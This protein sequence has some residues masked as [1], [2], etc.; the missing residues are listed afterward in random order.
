MQKKITI[1]SLLMIAGMC[2]AAFAATPVKFE[3][4]RLGLTLDVM[5]Q[6]AGITDT[7][8]VEIAE[9][10][11]IFAIAPNVTEIGTLTLDGQ[12]T[13]Y[14]VA[15]S[16]EEAPEDIQAMIDTLFEAQPT[17]LFFSSIFARRTPLV[18]SYQAVFA[19][20]VE[21]A[22][23]ARENVGREVRG[24]IGEMGAYLSPS[25]F[26]YPRGSEESV[27]FRIT[28]DIPAEWECV[29]DGNRSASETIDGRK[30]QT[31]E[32]PYRNDGLM[33]MAAPYVVRSTMR[34][35]IEVA[36]YFF[37]ADTGLFEQYLTATADYITMYTDLIGPYPFERFTVAEN[38][39]PTGYGMPG[40]T[41]LGQQVLRMPWIVHTSLG[42]E[43]L[44]NWWGNSVYV[45]YVR[46]NWCEAATVY[47]ADYRYKLMQS[48]AAARDYRKDILKEYLSYVGEGSDFPIRAFTSRT[49]PETRTIGYNKAMMVYHLIHE[50]I[51]DSA[52]FASWKD[53]YARYRGVKIGWEEWIESFERTSG[54]DLSFIIPQWIDGPGAPV[55]ELAKAEI[56]S[57]GAGVNTAEIVVNETSGD[58]YRLRVPVRFENATETLDTVVTIADGSGSVT[59]ALPRS[60]ET[61][62]V[63][64]EYNIFRKLY[65]VEVE[66]IISAV[67]GSES[68][69]YNTGIVE[70]EI[71]DKIREFIAN[72]EGDEVEVVVDADFSA[73]NQTI[74]VIAFNPGD[75]PEYLTDRIEHSEDQVA[76]GNEAY[77]LSKHSL[78]LAV[79]FETGGR[80]LVVLTKDLASLPRL[81]QLIPHYGK[82][83]YLVFEGTKNI[84]KGQWEVT[85]SPLKVELTPSR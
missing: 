79:D 33:F 15:H 35:D 47:G 65:D 80:G 66:P 81:G 27:K 11:N 44:H 1:A 18:I 2:A 9:G 16:S 57:D 26:F 39:F 36:C 71:A 23:F 67:I 61:V 55:L 75:L 78:V 38:F 10:L 52:F 7:C 63:D 8:I 53:I 73:A 30:H 6:T 56:R 5:Q 41:L 60:Y 40:W 82:Y 72:V 68:R 54:R 20:S 37:E 69:Q 4:H 76:L 12:W 58:N 46:G 29:A 84:A 34:G 48:P 62:H 22:R 43:V 17:V 19:E 42:H 31:W 21:G 14:G 24:T 83:S 85:Q 32:N 49:S 25:A 50:E 51:G 59:I 64:P 77:D 3:S 70:A 28:A 45:D 74:S 13:E